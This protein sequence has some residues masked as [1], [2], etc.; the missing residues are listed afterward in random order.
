VI[1][2]RI[3]RGLALPAEY[4]T[5]TAAIVAKRRVGKTYTG[6]VLAEEL[7][8]AGLPFYALDPTSAWWGLRSSAT[9]E[10]AG[11]PVVVIGGEHGDLPLDLDAGK[12]I[13]DLIVEEPSFYVNCGA[14]ASAPSAPAP[15]R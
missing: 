7:V 5:K 1:A 4:V 14:T 2:L 9:G 6:A 12:A 8:A 10:R 15:T 3:A 13:A 11:L